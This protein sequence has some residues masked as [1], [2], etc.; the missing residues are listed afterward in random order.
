MGGMTLGGDQFKRG[1]RS[2]RKNRYGER[3]GFK[4]ETVREGVSLVNTPKMTESN[5]KGGGSREVRVFSLA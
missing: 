4:N 1:E 5:G 2:T 3:Y